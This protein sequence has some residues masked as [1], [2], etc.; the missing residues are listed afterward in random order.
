MFVFDLSKI[1]TA[2]FLSLISGVVFY[3]YKG[4][5]K[6]LAN[7]RCYLLIALSYSVG[8]TTI[9]M[10]KYHG[11]SV[12][13]YLSM[14]LF[15]PL[16][17]YIEYFSVKFD[18]KR[19]HS[20]IL[21]S[22][23]ATAI[24]LILQFHIGQNVTKF[25]V[26]IP[27]AV[28][29]LILSSIGILFV[30]LPL[31]SGRLENVVNI[32]TERTGVFSWGFFSFI[33]LALPSLSGSAVAGTKSWMFGGMGQPSELVLKVTFPLFLA[34]FL[35]AKSDE[36][37]SLDARV[38]LKI[39]LW[40]AVLAFI[41]FFFPLVFMQK[42]NGTALVMALTFLVMITLISG[43][44]YYFILGTL[45]I[46]LS[47][48][49]AALTVNRLGERFIGGFLWWDS[50]INKS[51]L[52]GSDHTP[53]YQLFKSLAAVNGSNVWGVG[54]G[55]GDLGIPVVI[56]DFI[57][58]ALGESLGVVGLVLVLLLLYL[59][60]KESINSGISGFIGLFLT[61]ISST[62]LVQSLY[63]LSG[64]IGLL[65]MT[66]IPLPFISYGGSGLISCYIAIGFMVALVN[67]QK[68]AK[69]CLD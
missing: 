43:R 62:L 21:T 28:V 17:L 67:S 19:R 31:L 51:Y 12:A 5:E 65:P 49:V 23:A 60:L 18:Y 37:N 53:G 38:N 7:R 59:P 15:V 52:E 46:G 41:F 58:A 39:T 2:I 10:G 8:I 63:N 25:G 20:L 55:N 1:G 3:L 27:V 54:L 4:N 6:H 29:Q 56:S 32:V 14:L 68:E 42:E 57:G 24:G 33:L 26:R 61:G 30:F 9:F 64:T 36:L 44:I 34:K 45:M 11:H 66:G 22:L 69:P 13:L 47:M 16:L 40:L 48:T 50:Y 35:E